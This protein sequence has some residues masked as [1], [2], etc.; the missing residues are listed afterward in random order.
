MALPPDASCLSS[1]EKN[2]CAWLRICTAVLVPM[3]SSMRRQARPYRRS[4]S[5]KRVCSWSVH[6]SRCLVMT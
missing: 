2:F 1:L 4:A 5:R 6:F 3:W